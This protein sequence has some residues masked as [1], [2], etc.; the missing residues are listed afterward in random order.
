[1]YVG[2]H[3]NYIVVLNPHFDR[4]YVSVAIV[5]TILLRKYMLHA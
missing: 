5:Y 2:T 4:L 1:M 3:K